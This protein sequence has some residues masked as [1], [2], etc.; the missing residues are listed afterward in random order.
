MTLRPQLW[1]EGQ[2]EA[3]GEAKGPGLRRVEGDQPGPGRWASAVSP[4]SGLG[5][6]PEAES[7]TSMQVAVCLYSEF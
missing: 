3:A 1:W 7:K 6:S 4:D 2:G 5:T